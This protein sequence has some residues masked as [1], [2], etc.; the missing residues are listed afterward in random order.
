M[1]ILGQNVHFRVLRSSAWL[2]HYDLLVL[3]RLMYI[4]QNA[5][6]YIFWK[7]YIF[8]GNVHFPEMYIFRKCTSL[9]CTCAHVDSEFNELP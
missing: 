9:L 1:Y 4:S 8:C 3:V 7:M 2:S 6:M 5:K